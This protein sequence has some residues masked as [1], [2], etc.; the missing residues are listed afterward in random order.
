MVTAAQHN[1]TIVYT[2]ELTYGRDTFDLKS[3][4]Y[5]KDITEQNVLGDISVSMLTSRTILYHILIQNE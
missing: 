2:T 5:Q 1:I 3:I 4:P